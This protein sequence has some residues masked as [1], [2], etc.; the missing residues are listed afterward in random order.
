MRTHTHTH[1]LNLDKLIKM[2]CSIT[3]SET[4]F[5]SVDLYGAAVW[6]GA[7]GVSALLGFLFSV[8]IQF[9]NIMN[10]FW[11]RQSQRLQQHL[12]H[13]GVS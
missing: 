9:H 8:V 3:A 4:A 6:C 11:E 2:C 10:S 1:S 12:Q 13:Y 7:R 5:A